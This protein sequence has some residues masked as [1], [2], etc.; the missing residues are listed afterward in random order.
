LTKVLL[1]VAL[2]L[3]LSSSVFIGLYAGAQYN[4][5]LERR[6]NHGGGG[7]EESQPPETVTVTRIAT[8]TSVFTSTSTAAPPAPTTP[9][10]EV[11]IHFSDKLNGWMELTRIHFSSPFV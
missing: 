3:L 8:E 4:L 9:V 5:N 2:I 1:I 6:R 11:V 10:E 7:P